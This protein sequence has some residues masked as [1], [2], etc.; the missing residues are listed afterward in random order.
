MFPMEPSPD[1]TAAVVAAAAAAYRL[2]EIG[3]L[4]KMPPAYPGVELSGHFLKHADEQTIVALAAIQRATQQHNIDP[5][6]LA[7][8]GIIAAPRYIGRL[9]GA[10]VLYKF[11]R[12]GTSAVA[13][14]IVAQCSLHSVSGAASIALG[15][16]GPNVGVGGGEWAIADGMM[17][18]LSLFETVR[19]PGVW[20]LLSEFDSEPVPDEEGRPLND[21][22]CHAV[23][24]A[25][26]PGAAGNS[27][28]T[29][30]PGTHSKS[31]RASCP[32]PTVAEIAGCID[33]AERG[34]PARWACWLPWGGRVELH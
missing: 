16:H 24:L 18:A 17:A 2:S 8:W 32:Q 19:V 11:P 6:D 29:L 1:L 31:L 34:L 12:G 10:N 27:Q 25:L 30:R 26:M 3:P 9:T 23:A 21:P 4:R 13:P 33:A 22:T 7:G 28:L 14:H 5:R 15:M 20:L